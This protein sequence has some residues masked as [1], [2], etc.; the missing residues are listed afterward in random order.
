M[1]EYKKYHIYYHMRKSGMTKGNQMRTAINL[2]PA[3]K[4]TVIRRWKREHP[5]YVFEKIVR[6]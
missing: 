2:I 1:E 6:G 5:R 4:N 3:D